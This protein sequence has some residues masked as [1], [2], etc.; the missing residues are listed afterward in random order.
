MEQLRRAEARSLQSGVGT[1][2]RPP[3]DEAPL[4]AH[5]RPKTVVSNAASALANLLLRL[6]SPAIVVLTD[7]RPAVTGDA[8]HSMVSVGAVF[9][10]LI[11]VA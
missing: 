2:G 6:P 1:L 8:T 4:T 9:A 5:V 11:A 3:V 10:R 7:N